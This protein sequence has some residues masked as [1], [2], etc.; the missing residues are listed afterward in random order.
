MEMLLA[1]APAL[2]SKGGAGG[3]S[4]MLSNAGGLASSIGG[5]SQITDQF[6]ALG[7]SPE[8]I[9]QFANIAIN[10]FTQEGNNTGE[11]LQKG[12]SSIL[13]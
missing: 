3:L 5:L 13:G 8:M 7:L 12:L 10:Y 9:A 6:E 2:S 4:G 11:L 1:A